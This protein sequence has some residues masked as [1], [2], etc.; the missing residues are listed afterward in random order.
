L[1]KKLILRRMV[2]KIMTMFFLEN[3]LENYLKKV[4]KKMF[5]VMKLR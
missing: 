5:W 2:Y 1:G 4:L 3:P